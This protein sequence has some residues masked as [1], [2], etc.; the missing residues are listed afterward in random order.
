MLFDND[1][2]TLLSFAF[3]IVL[4][5]HHVDKGDRETG[6]S[7]VIEVWIFVSVF[8][9]GMKRGSFETDM[10]SKSPIAV[11]RVRK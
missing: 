3:E 2:T 4:Q 10:Q 11:M 7:A 8:P 9:F 5:E 1:A 6:A